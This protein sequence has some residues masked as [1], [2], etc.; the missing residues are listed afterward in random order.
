LKSNTSKN[1]RPKEK[2]KE[3]REKRFGHVD[4]YVL[5]DQLQ[6]ALNHALT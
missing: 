5:V 3:K 1:R 4:A 6:P 2:E